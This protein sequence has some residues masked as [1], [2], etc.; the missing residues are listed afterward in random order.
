MSE[1]E[2]SSFTLFPPDTVFF[3]PFEGHVTI[4]FPSED[5]AIAFYQFLRSFISGEIEL[6]AVEGRK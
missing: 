2:V 6:E 1:E 3:P 4:L 5:D